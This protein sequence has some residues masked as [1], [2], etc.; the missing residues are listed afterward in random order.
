MGRRALTEKRRASKRSLSASRSTASCSSPKLFTHAVAPH[1]A[2][3]TCRVRAA[4]IG[5][6]ITQALADMY[7]LGLLPCG[8]ACGHGGM[9]TR[10]RLEPSTTVLHA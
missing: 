3:R 1:D 5:T 7:V 4:S 10:P 8:Q 2:V 6:S 9:N